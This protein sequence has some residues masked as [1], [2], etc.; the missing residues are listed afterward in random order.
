MIRS[1]REG[2]RGLSK[3]ISAAGV[4]KQQVKKPTFSRTETNFWL[5]TAM[6]VVFLA[7]IFVSVVVR[8][9]FPTAASTTGWTLWGASL[10]QWMDYQ[11]GLLGLF[12]F[13]VLV[14]LMLHW[15]WV[16]GVVTSRMFRARD[17]NKPE[18][19]FTRAPAVPFAAEEPGK[20]VRH[21]T[22]NLHAEDT[23]H[24][25]VSVAHDPVRK[26]NELLEGERHLKG[27]LKTGDEVV[28]HARV[29]PANW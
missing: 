10:D 20:Q 25:Q 17:G 6:L 23:E 22:K 16:C 27:T 1:V 19:P 4:A 26:V 12:C 21:E 18:V 8:F 14:H 9:V 28:D 24:D 5:D 13:A 15:N 11:F 3:E 29:E 7:L 2:P